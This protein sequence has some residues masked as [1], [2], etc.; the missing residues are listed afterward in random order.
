MLVVRDRTEHTVTDVV[1]FGC[2]SAEEVDKVIGKNLDGDYIICVLTNTPVS[3]ALP[4]IR[5]LVMKALI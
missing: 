1:I 5:A 4:K 2:P 3:A